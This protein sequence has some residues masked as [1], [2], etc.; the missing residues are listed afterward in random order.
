M[1]ATGKEPAA[2]M[3]RIRL[4]CKRA[5]LLLANLGHGPGVRYA[6]N[7][8]G[9]CLFL[10]VLSGLLLSPGLLAQTI[11][12]PPIAW[13]HVQVSHQQQQCEALKPKARIAIRLPKITEALWLRFSDHQADTRAAFYNSKNQR[14]AVSNTW[15]WMEGRYGLFIEPQWLLDHD[16]VTIERYDQGQHT[17]QICWSIEPLIDSLVTNNQLLMYRQYNQ[18]LYWRQV[19]TEQQQYRLRTI[20]AFQ[21]AIET[22]I[23]NQHLPL[24]A[25]LRYEL[26]LFLQEKSQHDPAWLAHSVQLLSRAATQLKQLNW[27]AMEASALNTLGLI[28]SDKGQVDLALDHFQRAL[29]LREQLKQP[30][31]AA[32]SH[33]NLGLLY[34]R[35][36]R[37]LEAQ[38]HFLTAARYFLCDQDIE[39]HDVDFYLQA[40]NIC[41]E[42]KSVFKTL[43]N[44]GLVFDGLG[45]FDQAEKLWLLY[46]NLPENRQSASLRASVQNNLGAMYLKMGRYSNALRYLHKANAYFNQGGEAYW[47]ALTQGNLGKVNA[48]LGR[49]ERAEFYFRSALATEQT[50]KVFRAQHWHDLAVLLLQDDTEQALILLAR[51]EQ[52]YRDAEQTKELV[53]TLERKAQ[54]MVRLERFAEAKRAL[55]EALQLSDNTA[56]VRLNGRVLA[57]LGLVYLAEKRYREAEYT[58]LAALQF[59]QESRDEL[60][61]LEISVGMVQ[62]LGERNDPR[63]LDFARQALDLT[64]TL[65]INMVAPSLRAEFLAKQRQVFELY[66]DLLMRAGQ[67]HEAWEITERS[68]SRSLL[69]LTRRRQVWIQDASG[70]ALQKEQAT[71]FDEMSALADLL[72][73]YDDAFGKEESGFGDSAHGELA[74]QWQYRLHAINDELDLIDAQLQNAS[75]YNQPKVATL[76]EFQRVI[77][78]NTVVLSYFLGQE[79]SYLWRIT[80]NSIQTFSLPNR[81]RIKQQA[82]RFLKSVKRSDRAVGLVRQEAAKLRQMLWPATLNASM[83]LAENQR[84]VLI[85]DGILHQLPSEWLWA[86]FAIKPSPVL[87]LSRISSASMLL[88]LRQR[89]GM[90]AQGVAVLADPEVGADQALSILAGSRV[91]ADTIMK[92]LR[93]HAR[94]WR[95]A[96]LNRASLLGD[97]LAPFRVVHIAT[98]GLV[99]ERLPELS[100]LLLSNNEETQEPEFLYPNDIVNL[101]LN[102]ELVVLSSCDSARGQQL[103][104]E[105]VLSIARPFF[106]A[107]ARQVVAS[108]WQVS[109]RAGAAFMQQ[110]YQHYQAHQ[111]ASAAL[112][113]AKLWM[114]QQREWSHPYYWAGFVIQG[115]WQSKADQNGKGADEM[116]AREA[117]AGEMASLHAQ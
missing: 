60:F 12:W 66:V 35:S 6:L 7:V 42:L 57:N 109:D 92:T 34:Q 100:A 9:F 116:S 24:Q 96:S 11:I 49:T 83:S 101:S 91:E 73:S 2:V 1:K 32:I 75:E 95:G 43:N 10:F 97:A 17:A 114:S 14:L 107:G 30:S 105:G 112:M 38:S 46:L 98:H 20:N 84:V 16:E 44:L 74:A 86:D 40:N 13:S 64:E 53:K 79:H 18:A 65:R 72:E 5:V 88:E 55:H 56:A 115:D 85:L 28:Y 102:A 113:A 99:N 90:E 63:A 106:I 104:G 51:A 15:A 23:D 33:S 61:R 82:E 37:L 108:L 26:G 111:N 58:L 71:L 89:Q 67:A 78:E 39:Y 80:A 59:A 103:E 21:S 25:L 31:Q 68:R 47:K 27:P 81:A 70:A 19:D 29:S 50:S 52:V 117:T 94:L 69:D 62:A 76:A 22:T 8:R 110:F 87:H 45:E 93:P 77:D 41:G 54:A 4:L 48:A 3:E 36:T